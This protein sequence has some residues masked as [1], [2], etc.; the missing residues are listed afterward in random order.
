MAERRDLRQVQRNRKILWR[1]GLLVAACGLL[2][3]IFMPGRGLLHYYKL[4]RNV[5]T[6]TQ[7]NIRLQEANNALTEEIHRLKTDDACIEN[8]ARKKHG[9]LKKNEEVYDFNRYNKKK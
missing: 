7:D 6:L 9:M 5:Q 1:I 3:L 4:Q 8:L 2:L